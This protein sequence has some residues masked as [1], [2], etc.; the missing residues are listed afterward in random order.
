[1]YLNISP[2]PLLTGC[3][4]Q[5]GGGSILKGDTVHTVNMI[6][7]VGCREQNVHC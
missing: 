7:T 3:S 6:G 2:P 5:Y 4:V 1:M